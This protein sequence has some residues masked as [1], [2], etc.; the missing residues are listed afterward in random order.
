MTA[1][2]ALAL[3]LVAFVQPAF[4][5]DA[6]SPAGVYD[7]S[8]VEIG[9]ELDLQPDGR[10]TYILAYGSLDERAAGTWSLADGA[11]E[12]TSDP[13]VAPAFAL[14]EAGTGRGGKL[15]IELATPEGIPPQFFAARLVMADGA[16]T[17]VDFDGPRASVAVAKSNP[18]ATIEMA[19]PMYEAISPPF[20]LAPDA[21]RLRFSFAPND[22]GLVAFEHQL[23]PWEGGGYVLERHGR[24][25]V[26]RKRSAEYLEEPVEEEW[27][28]D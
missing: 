27:S 16:E 28:E 25:L 19:F 1:R 8:Q 12:L 26:F 14:E 18:P 5:D 7:G 23:L 11:L 2:F 6:P 10:F 9:A 17:F 13:V 20:P 15:H 3:A 4:A 21:R 24:R 22:L